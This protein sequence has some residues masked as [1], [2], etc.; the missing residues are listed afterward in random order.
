VDRVEEVL[1]FDYDLRSGQRLGTG[2]DVI[3]LSAD[4]L[5]LS[6]CPQVVVR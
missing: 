4:A 2:R 3:R 5:F 1:L 6:A